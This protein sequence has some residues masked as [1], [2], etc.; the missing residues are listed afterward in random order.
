MV[1]GSRLSIQL[2]ILVNARGLIAR[3]MCP[4]PQKKLF[5]IERS[6]YLF[7]F[8]LESKTRCVQYRE[9]MKNISNKSA[10]NLLILIS[11]IFVSSNNMKRGKFFLTD[12]VDFWLY[13]D[14]DLRT[15]KKVSRWWK[16]VYENCSKLSI[17]ININP[18][19][20]QIDTKQ[21]AKY[22]TVADSILV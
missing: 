21:Y 3:K 20:S 1:F 5:L 8:L 2:L 10:Q 9:I 12:F 4:Y 19:L 15:G 22:W 14:L 6:N 18:A 17:A 11:N 13:T 16:A 7:F